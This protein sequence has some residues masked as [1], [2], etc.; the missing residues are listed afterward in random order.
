MKNTDAKTAAIRT[1]AQETIKSKPQKRRKQ[2]MM[3]M[4]IDMNLNNTNHNP[5][6]LFNRSFKLN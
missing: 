1:P 5:A 4:T 3:M 2:M 6:Y